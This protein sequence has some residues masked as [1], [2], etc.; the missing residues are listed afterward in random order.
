MTKTF[1]DR[2]GREIMGWNDY[3]LLK[4]R[5][6]YGKIN[7]FSYNKENELWKDGDKYLC[8]E[9]EDSYIHWFMNPETEDRR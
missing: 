6:L 7:I 5:I 8:Q 3:G 1:C 4:H 2:C 9:C